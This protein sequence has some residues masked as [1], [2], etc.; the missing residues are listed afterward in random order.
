VDGVVRVPVA[1][2][3]A[4]DISVDA[5][6]R[7]IVSGPAIEKRTRS[8]IV[9]RYFSDGRLDTSFGTHGIARVRDARHRSRC[10]GRSRRGS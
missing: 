2:A 9:A 1:F 10:R 8:V 7:L 5:Q 6:G 3:W 4:G